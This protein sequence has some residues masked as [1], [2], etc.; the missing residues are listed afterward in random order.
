MNESVEAMHLEFI[1]Y[2]AWANRR[3]LAACEAL[4][5]EQL[6]AGGP[7]A[8]GTIARTLE[9]LVDTESFYTL[10]LSGQG[11]PAPFDWKASPPPTVAA[12]RAYYERVAQALLAAAAQ[13]TPETVVHQR[14]Q[15]GEASYKALA[16]LI[17]AVNH[18]VEH[19][20]NITTILSSLGVPTPEVDGW[21]Y[22]W[23][24]RERL[25]AE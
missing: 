8:Y 19:R 24:N 15:G 9:H 11:V 1:R 2:N 18:G 4:T 20:T 21:S 12:I 23:G 25:G 10:L 22:M 6:A 7:G 3:L 17:Q 16:L 14:W 13:V 5:A